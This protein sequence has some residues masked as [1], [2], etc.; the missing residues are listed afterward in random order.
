[1]SRTKFV[2]SVTYTLSAP[3]SPA[4]TTAE[5]DVIRPALSFK[6]EEF[7]CVAP[8]S[9]AVSH[10]MVVPNGTTAMFSEYARAPAVSAAAP[11]EQTGVGQS[12]QRQ[13]CP[14]SGGSR[15]D[16]TS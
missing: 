1:M 9:H 16:G 3:L 7:G 8:V 5:F 14:H 4:G 15:R 12:A 10:R 6:V 2:A 11:G 13:G